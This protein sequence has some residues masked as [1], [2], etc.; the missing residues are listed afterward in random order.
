MTPC[1]PSWR[2]NA[3]IFN[4]SLVADPSAPGERVP[5]ASADL[6]RWSPWFA[7]LLADRCGLLIA[8]FKHIYTHH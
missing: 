7:A 6:A 5:V 4:V 3:A 2:D 8:V 1:T